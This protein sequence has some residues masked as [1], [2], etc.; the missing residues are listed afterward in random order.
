[1]NSNVNVQDFELPQINPNN[2]FDFEL[3]S[4]AKTKTEE[5][6]N[7]NN[8]SNIENNNNSFPNFT[9]ETYDIK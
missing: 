6:S 5:V 4:L 8:V 7:N 2:T 9:S 3:P 1:M